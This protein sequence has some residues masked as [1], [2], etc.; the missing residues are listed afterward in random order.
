[1]QFLG[2]LIFLIFLLI[3][4]WYVKADFFFILFGIAVYFYIL[5]RIFSIRPFD[6]FDS[7]AEF[8]I[9]YPIG[10]FLLVLPIIIYILYNFIKNSSKNSS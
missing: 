4:L 1:M 2:A 3:L 10:L 9:A 7:V 8:V 5:L 6:V